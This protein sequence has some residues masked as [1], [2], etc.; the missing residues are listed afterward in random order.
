MND[1]YPYKLDPWVEFHLEAIPVYGLK[2]K[3]DF[4]YKY[5]RTTEN[6]YIGI[7]NKDNL[8]LK[9][10][11]VLLKSISSYITNKQFEDGTTVDD[12]SK[13]LFPKVC[14]LTDS[15]FKTGF[16][17][18][19]SV[20]Y[21]PR[22]QSNVIHPGSIRNHVIKLFQT[23]PDVKCLYFNTG[24]VKFDFM[25]S[26]EVFQL[27]ES[28]DLEF[29]LVADHGSIIPHINLDRNSV[30]TNILKWQEF[31]YRRFDSSTFTVDSKIGLFKPWQSSDANISIDMTTATTDNMCRALILA[32]LG[33]DYESDT[34]SVKHK[35]KFATP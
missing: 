20:H 23:T 25:E 31:I 10:S 30:K 12:F 22:I 4:F 32:L 9:S 7:I 8:L 16:N 6:L 34:L 26:M 14:W 27:T 3:I 17:F 35:N 11:E 1:S 19:V 33:K 21:N 2:N 5:K 24:G 13:R 18:P 28:K 29:E 15:F